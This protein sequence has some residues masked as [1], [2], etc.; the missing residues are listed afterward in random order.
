MVVFDVL[1]RLGPETMFRLHLAVQG[2]ALCFVVVAWQRHIAAAV[3]AARAAA[4]LLAVAGASFYVGTELRMHNVNM[5]SLALVSAAVLGWR[6]TAPAGLLIGANLALKPYGAALLLPWMAWHGAWRWLA[7]SLAA[8]LLFFVAL[9]VAWFGPATTIALYADWMR[10]LAVVATPAAMRQNPLSLQA[11][12]AAVM[13]RDLAL[14]EVVAIT[15]ALGAAWL[16]LVAA[17]LLMAARPRAMPAGERLA[18]QVGALLMTPLPLGPLQ[19]P[20]RGAALLVAMLAI[21][22]G[23]CD[24]ARPRAARAAMA[25]IVAAVAV[26]PRLVPMGPL[27][28]GLTLPVCALV[29][30]ALTILHRSAKQE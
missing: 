30:L 16:A 11:A 24:P 4:A 1:R 19:Q 26:A 22:H 28:A 10:E 14:P 12:V 15:R 17:Y 18:A 8:A 27:H 6:R 9:P 7:A 5:T 29:L 21:A 3:P 20:G 13:D 2:L 23:V 25:A